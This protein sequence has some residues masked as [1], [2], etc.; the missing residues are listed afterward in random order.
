MP[1]IWII[2]FPLK[3]N[4]FFINLSAAL[5]PPQLFSSTYYLFGQQIFHVFLILKLSEFGGIVPS[6]VS[7][8]HPF[9]ARE[10]LQKDIFSCIRGDRHDG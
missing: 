7:E 8:D 5:Q 10:I 9:Q 2:V 1:E 4:S 6:T 3:N